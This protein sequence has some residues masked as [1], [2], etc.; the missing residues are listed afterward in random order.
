ML[1]RSLRSFLALNRYGTIVAAA[2]KVHLSQA[3]VSVQLK[4]MEDELDIPL[5]VLSG[6]NDDLAPPAS[7]RP[8]FERSRSRDKTYRTVPLGHID[9]LVGRDA[10]F[11]T[12]PLVTNWIEKRS[13]A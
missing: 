6:M 5:F 9:L 2:E 8:A 12:W 11:A 10:P 7:V 13:A 4:N 1:I 3:A